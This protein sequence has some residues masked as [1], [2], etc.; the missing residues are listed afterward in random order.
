MK[1]SLVLIIFLL[2][3]RG[4]TAE[5]QQPKKIPRIGYLTAVGSAPIGAFLQRLRDLGYVEGKN[6]LVEFR[7]TGGKSKRLPELAAELVRLKVDVIVADTAAEV[8]AA[9]NTTAT[10]PIVMRSV[11]DP[12]A[13]GLVASLAHP[14]GN[15]TGMASLSP[16]LSGKRLELLKEV[17]PKL[18]RVPFLASPAPA[19]RT[20][21]KETEVAA[22]ALGLKLQIL[23]VRAVDELE[24]MFDATKKQVPR[25]WCN[26]QP[27]Q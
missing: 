22:Q 13:L 19:W 25:L 7:S 23:Q 4:I 11:S 27:A 21:I 17:I 15:I 5:A 12:I 9:K 26:F 8:T 16:E 10:I 1:R 18:S 20:S 2:A 24:G 3:A 14:G 6:M